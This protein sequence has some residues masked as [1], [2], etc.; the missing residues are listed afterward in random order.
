[1]TTLSVSFFSWAFLFLL[2]LLTFS[3][4]GASAGMSPEEVKKFE[5]FK[6]L[7]ERGDAVAQF[8]LGRCYHLGLGTQVEKGTAFLWWKKSAEQGN[9]DA[10]VRYG[11]CFGNGD[12][13]KMDWKQAFNWWLKASEQGMSIA[14]NNLGYCLEN[15]KGTKKD[16]VEAYAYYILAAQGES[17]AQFGL[18]ALEKKLTAPEILAGKKR[19][20]EL[21][22]EI[23]A[24]IAAK[25]AGK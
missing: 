12:V 14:H 1:M 25:K 19:A 4:I 21:Q 13:V 22:K 10:Q 15:G 20:E 11:T 16:V 17:I 6:L 2:G 8:E 7:A 24:K 9:A 3:P 23:E 18:L 5:E